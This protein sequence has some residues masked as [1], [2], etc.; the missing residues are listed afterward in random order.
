ML[1]AINKN[2][3]LSILF[4]SCF[5]QQPHKVAPHALHAGND[6]RGEGLEAGPTEAGTSSL[7]ALQ[8][9]QGR[10]PA[11]CSGNIQPNV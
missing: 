3:P 4:L 6:R 11:L 1:T 2:Q 9:M 8:D 7:H 10:G 5:H